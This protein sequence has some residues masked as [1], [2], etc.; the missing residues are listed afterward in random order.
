MLLMLFDRLSFF[1]FICVTIFFTIWSWKAYKLI[2]EFGQLFR[3]KKFFN[4]VLLI[5]D[6]E[7]TSYNFKDIINK[8]IVLQQRLPASDGS[9]QNAHDIVSRLM[10]RENYLI[11]LFNKDVIDLTLPFSKNPV[12]TKL[13]EWF[14]SFSILTYFFDESLVVKRAFLKDINRATMADGLRKRFKLL[15][16]ISFILSPFLFVFS[17]IYFIF[18]YGEE[19]YKN[20]KIIGNREYTTYA[21]W[22]L[23]E[24]HEL[25][26]LFEQRL[27]NSHSKAA[28]Y[29]EQFHNATMAGVGKFISFVT[30][31]L[32]FVMILLTAYNEDLLMHFEITPGKSIIWYLALFGAILAISRSMIPDVTRTRDPERLMKT[33]AEYTHY[34]PNHWKDR[35]RSEEVR[36]EFGRLYQ[37]QILSFTHELLSVFT[38]PILLWFVFPKQSERIVDF[39]REFT[40]HVDGIGYVCSFGLF[41]F[42]RHGNPNYGSV[43]SKKNANDKYYRSKQGKMEKSFINFASNYPDWTPDA[44]GSMYLDRLKE[45]DASQSMIN[46]KESRFFRS[47]KSLHMHPGFPDS[48][49]DII[50]ENHGL[51]SLLNDY[52]DHNRLE[53]QP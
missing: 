48:D 49:E 39:F 45:F 53:M 18:K 5:N 17:L 24:F 32:C 28:K 4:K 8:L 29:M 44:Q 47:K 19:V 52:Y 41:D 21:R 1:M 20:P 13:T 26:H 10:R 33:I 40:V 9:F 35:L 2:S 46:G 30:G 27:A 42:K 22:K 6:T 23:R 43:I 14:L 3:M 11:A 16:F 36:S 51:L 15:A 50:D 7:L 34:M 25:P 38:T 31:S 12:L 37:Y